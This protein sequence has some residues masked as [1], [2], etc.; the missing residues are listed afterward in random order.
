M[1]CV[2]YFTLQCF[3]RKSHQQTYSDCID[4]RFMAGERL[5]AHAISNVPQLTQTSTSRHLS[6]TKPHFSNLYN[7]IDG[8]YKCRLITGTIRF[9]TNFVTAE[10]RQM[11]NDTLMCTHNSTGPTLCL[12]TYAQPP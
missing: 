9:V 10:Y 11:L 3:K 4:V 8:G 5:F 12:K 1:V 2:L 6:A 7:T